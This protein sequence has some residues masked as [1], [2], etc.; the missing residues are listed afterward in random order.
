MTCGCGNR[1]VNKDN[2]INIEIIRKLIQTELKLQGLGNNNNSSVEDI[3]KELELLKQKIEDAKQYAERAQDAANHANSA[4]TQIN[5]MSAQMTEK[6]K[7]GFNVTG[8][9]DKLEIKHGIIVRI[10]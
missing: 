9:T 5:T 6:L 4:L 10:K 2:S 8:E 3:K 1:Q 7:D